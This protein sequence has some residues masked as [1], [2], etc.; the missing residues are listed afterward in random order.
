MKAEAPP[1]DVSDGDQPSPEAE[2]AINQTRNRPLDRR[3]HNLSYQTQP[4]TGFFEVS[5]S[6]FVLRGSF[7]VALT[8]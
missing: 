7:T 5:E 1:L 6:F 4:K 8:A 2:S 3:S